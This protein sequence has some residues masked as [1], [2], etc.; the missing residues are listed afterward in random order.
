MSWIP[1]MNN[2]VQQMNLNMQQLSRNSQAMHISGNEAI[3]MILW[4]CLC[5]TA[6]I[7]I[8]WNLKRR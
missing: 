1:I 4:I 5:V 6:L 7:W 2:N 3:F 8:F